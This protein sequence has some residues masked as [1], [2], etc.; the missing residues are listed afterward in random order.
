MN[1][2]GD[3][4]NTA[5]H[6]NNAARHVNNAARHVNNAARHVNNAAGDVNKG[7]R[8]VIS[9][10]QCAWTACNQLCT[11]CLYLFYPISL[12]RRTF[13]VITCVVWQLKLFLERVLTG[14]VTECLQ[15]W[16][17]TYTIQIWVVIII[18]QFLLCL[19]TWKS[20]SEVHQNNR[21]VRS[22]NR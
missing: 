5:R 3:V 9:R 4:N 22:Q 16:H 1:N 12:W 14:R 8:L 21:F 13:P 15:E 6:V 18:R 11:W 10:C 20:S 7:D 19:N 17:Q 2:W